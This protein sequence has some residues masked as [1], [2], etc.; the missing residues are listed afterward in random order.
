MVQYKII[1]ALYMKCY[2]IVVL[3]V[4]ENRFFQM[5]TVQSTLW[6]FYFIFS[7]DLTS[8]SVIAYC[9][10]CRVYRTIAC[11]STLLYDVHTMIHLRMYLWGTRLKVHLNS[12]RIFGTWRGCFFTA[13][14]A[15]CIKTK[16]EVNKYGI[17]DYNKPEET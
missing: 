15:V 9:Y 3:T 2:V 13:T 1:R 4:H 5:C 10:V 17:I 6:N 7:I 8:V 14:I 12:S 11:S 16:T